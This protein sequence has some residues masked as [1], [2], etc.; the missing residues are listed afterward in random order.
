MYSSSRDID[1]AIP[2]RCADVSLG[3]DRG[4]LKLAEAETADIA[5]DAGASGGED[6]SERLARAV[7]AAAAV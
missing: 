2:A 3:R 1:R 4:M 7:R 5:V 6:E